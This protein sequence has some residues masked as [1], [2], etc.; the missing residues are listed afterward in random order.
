MRALAVM[1][2]VAL[3]A[4]RPA[5]E[6]GGEDA[7]GAAGYGSLVGTNIA[8]VSLPASLNHRVIGPDTAVTM[9]F[10][11]ERLNIR[12]DGD[13]VITELDCG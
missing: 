7:C 8:A 6:P 5:E 3:A 12:V 11:A 13:G 1:G 4:C 9:D 10:I 2:M